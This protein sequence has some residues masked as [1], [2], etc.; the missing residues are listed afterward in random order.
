MGRLFF[1]IIWIPVVLLLALFALSNRFVET[2][3]LWP[4]PWAMELPAYV[5]VLVVLLGGMLIMGIAYNW[6]LFLLR[7]QMHGIRRRLKAKEAE[8]LRE[9]EQRRDLAVKL[10]ECQSEIEKLQKPNSTPSS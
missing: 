2:Y 5:P 4:L 1:Y 6:R 9:V 3:Q 8:Y 7:R 10:Q